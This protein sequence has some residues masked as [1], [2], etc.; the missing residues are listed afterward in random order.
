MMNQDL[1]AGNIGGVEINKRR[2]TGLVMAIIALAMGIYMV[3][4]QVS[5]IWGLLLFFPFLGA[6]LGF[7]QASRKTCIGLAAQGKCNFGDGA[8][9]IA[10]QELA[11]RLKDEGNLI[12]YRSII[13]ALVLTAATVLIFRIL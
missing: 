5:P 7:M 9:P 8:K 2:T 1:P 10:D 4:R 6:M 13:A 3:I 12:V 11:L